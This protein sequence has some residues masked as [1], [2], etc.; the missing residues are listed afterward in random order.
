MKV[1]INHYLRDYERNETL[2]TYDCELSVIPSVGNSIKVGDSIYI[3]VVSVCFCLDS[4]SVTITSNG[5]NVSLLDEFIDAGF[6]ITG[7][8]RFGGTSE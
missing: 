3:D 4:N 1:K 2:V 5:S 8:S 6:S 7:F